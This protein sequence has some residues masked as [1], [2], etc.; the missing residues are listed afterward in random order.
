MACLQK[1]VRLKANPGTSPSATTIEE[2][3]GPGLLNRLMRGLQVFAA[4]LGGQ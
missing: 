1:E 4:E 2:I 3:A